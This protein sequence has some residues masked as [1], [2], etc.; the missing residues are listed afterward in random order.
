MVM[1]G[2]NCWE[3]VVGELMGYIEFEDW[4]IQ[5]IDTPQFQ[6]LRD[7]KQLG[8]GFYVFPG[9]THTR[10][11]HSLGTTY[12]A[13]NLT[14]RLQEQQGKNADDDRNLKCVTLAADLDMDHIVIYF[15]KE[16]LGIGWKQEEGSITMF[17]DFLNKNLIDLDSI[18]LKKPDDVE[19][20][21]ALIKVLKN[22][23]LVRAID[24]MICDVLKQAKQYVEKKFEVESFKILINAGEKYM[25]LSDSIFYEI[26][27]SKD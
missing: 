14:K 15:I 13:Y 18:G 3:S 11:E 12:L 4:V 10:F 27:Q 24:H 8:T 23:N 9:A 20:I 26:E 1:S 2:S 7:I 17:E 22:A 16:C 6:R 25:R 21:K 5:F 19:I